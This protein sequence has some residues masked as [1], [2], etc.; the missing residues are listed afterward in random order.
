MPFD[1]ARMSTHPFPNDKSGF[2][3]LPA[4]VIEWLEMIRKWR[5]NHRRMSAR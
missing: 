2:D 3:P 5:L 4:T 1:A